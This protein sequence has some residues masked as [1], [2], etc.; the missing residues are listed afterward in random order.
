MSLTKVSYS[1]INGA[2]VN[3]LDYGADPTGSVDSSPAFVLALAA[4]NFVYVPAGTYKIDSQID[5]TGVKTITGPIG[6]DNGYQVAILN[7]TA[8]SG[9]VF[10]AT[11][12]E[13]SGISIQN[14]YIRGGNGSYAIESS[15]PLTNIDHIVME[16]YDGGGVNLFNAGTG[17]TGGWGSTI[18][19][20]KWVGPASL[21]TY[22]GYNI[23]TNGGH[24]TLE[25]CTALRGQIG[26]NIDQCEA[27]NLIACSINKQGAGYAAGTDS[28]IASIRLSGAGYK[29]A[30]SIRNCYLEGYVN[31]IYVEKCESLSIEDN[32]M[33]DLGYAGGRTGYGIYLKDTN[34][35]N[36]TIRNNHFSENSTQ[37]NVV[38]GNGANNV[39][40]ENNYMY[41]YAAGAACIVNGTSTTV[42]YQN[43]KFQYNVTGYAIL[44]PD[45][46]LVNQDYASGGFSSKQIVSTLV[47]DGIWNDLVSVGNYDI[48]QIRLT[49]GTSPSWRHCYDV[50][51]DG[52]GVSGIETVY[53]VNSGSITLSIQVSG[54]KIQYKAAGGAAQ[55]TAIASKVS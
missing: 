37:G 39:I 15:R 35:N 3:V 27:V 40:I 1:M 9:G 22:R 43:N 24:V 52:S 47:S 7:H 29:K 55:V 44:D 32:Y 50:Y 45:L 17:G 41:A 26:I 28:E 14:F 48:W 53:A 18:R 19:N 25:N 38:V 34:V 2:P 11:S 33:A 42:R 49:L 4:G 21:T 31:G 54:G 10:S 13:Y 6:L 8:A 51:I 12:D 30:I 16:V 20:C 5:I 46:T 36:V 23:D